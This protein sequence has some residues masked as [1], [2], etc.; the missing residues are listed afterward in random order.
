MAE[1]LGSPQ[2]DTIGPPP[3]SPDS[4][5]WKWDTVTPRVQEE[6]IKNTTGPADLF[7]QNCVNDKV[8]GRHRYMDGPLQ[9]GAHLNVS[10]SLS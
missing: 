1:V 9:P 8:K 10:A 5:A 6:K 7:F 2:A 3:N 4:S